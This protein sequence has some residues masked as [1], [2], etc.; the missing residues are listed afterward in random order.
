MKFKKLNISPTQS[1]QNAGFDWLLGDNTLPYVT[2]EM[3]VVTKKEAE[4]YY[5]TA[6]EL[7]EMFIEAAQYVIDNDKF[8]ELGIPEELVE[9]VKF[10]W[11]NDKNWH[12]YG[13]FDLS[14]GLDGKPIKL[15][16]FNADTATCIP[17][18][19]TVQWASLKANG[20]DESS[21]FNTLYESLVSQF[22]ELK[23]Q[24]NEFEPTL[25]ISTM[26]GYP[27]DDTNMQL[28]GEAAEEA[29]FEVSFEHIENVEFSVE[30]GIYKQNIED[31]SFTRYDFWFKLVPWEY[32]GWDEPELADIL[33]QIVQ[34]KKAVVMNP[35][36]TLLFQSKGILKVLWELYPNHSLLLETDNKPIVNKSCVQKVLFGR[37]GANVKILSESGISL[38]NTE[39]EYHE[40][41]VIYQEFTEFLQDETG[42]YYQAG[43]FFAGEGAGLGF[44]CGGKIIDNKAQFCGHI[45]A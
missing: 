16:E 18:T 4:N 25:L 38:E 44:R 30:Q 33:T 24:N 37:E 21:Q 11:E 6:N 5:E 36:Y 41:N 13:R 31:G 40:Q 26:E 1:L 19:A 34:S 45:I 17:E 2:N 15:I 12:L 7:Y 28:L 14:G 10:S 42:K 22:R 39:G 23:N 3:V 29:G 43:V 8:A 9:L 27:E 20:L 35:T 32:I